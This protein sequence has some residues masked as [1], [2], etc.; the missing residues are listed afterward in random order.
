M[1]QSL[2]MELQSR[3]RTRVTDRLPL[4]PLLCVTLSK[5]PD[6]VSSINLA[7]SLPKILNW[8]PRFFRKVD[9]R[10]LEQPERRERQSAVI[11][12][13]SECEAS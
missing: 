5:G 11:I 4:G 2:R 12:V 10:R 1:D 6:G 9:I 7:L 3:V 8:V 13:F